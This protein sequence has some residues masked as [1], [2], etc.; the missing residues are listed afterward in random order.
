MRD[1]AAF[2]ICSFRTAT[3]WMFVG[4]R[5]LGRPS[6]KSSSVSRSAKLRIT[7]ADDNGLRHG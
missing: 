1:G 2:S 4:S 7:G 6:V 3:F 5:R